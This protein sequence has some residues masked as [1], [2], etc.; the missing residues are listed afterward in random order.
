M[1]HNEVDYLPLNANKVRMICDLVEE[2]EDRLEFFWNF[3]AFHDRW[4]H[5]DQSDF[6]QEI[7]IQKGAEIA[8]NA[9]PPSE[10]AQRPENPVAIESVGVEYLRQIIEECQSRNIEILLTY[11]PFPA[12]EERWQEALYVERL[13]EEYG[14]AY[15]NF[16]DMQVADLEV[17]CSDENS[18]L[19][20]IMRSPITERRRPM[21]TG[22]KITGG[23]QN[24]SFVPWEIWSR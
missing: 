13:A 8:F 14:V 10:I 22:R 24:I 21:L 18:H 2:P 5:L 23:I 9:V 16:L 20:N 17:D 11:L 4:W 7:N 15:I 12:S 3:I 6:E 19:K 1:L